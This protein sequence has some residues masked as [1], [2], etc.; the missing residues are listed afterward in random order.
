MKHLTHDEIFKSLYPVIN[1]GNIRRTAAAWAQ[2]SSQPEERSRYL[3]DRYRELGLDTEIITLFPSPDRVSETSCQAVK[4]LLP[5]KSA[6]IFFI[7]TCDS[8]AGDLQGAA[9]LEAAAALKRAV[10]SGILPPLEYSLCFF[11]TPRAGDFCSWAKE[12]PDAAGGVFL[13]PS[14][15]PL[16]EGEKESFRLLQELNVHPSLQHIMGR[17]VLKLLSQTGAFTYAASEGSA[18][19]ADL[20]QTF[21]WNTLQFS[22][23]SSLLS[24]SFL[25]TLAAFAALLGASAALEKYFLPAYLSQ[26]SCSEWQ[27]IFRERSLEALCLKEKDLESRMLRG[28]RLSQWSALALRSAKTAIQDPLLEKEFEELA[29][30]E[31]DAA[32]QLLC[33]GDVPRF[34]SD[35]NDLILEPLCRGP[36]Q[37]DTGSTFC[38]FDGRKTVFETARELWAC[39]PFGEHESWENFDEFLSLT[40][41][42]AENALKAGAARSVPR[43]CVTG[44]ELKDALRELGVRPGDILMVHSSY[45]S[46]G[47]FEGGPEGVVK[48]LQESVTSAG[49]LAMPA[50]SDCCDGGVSGVFD[51]EHTPVEKPVGIIPETFRQMEGVLRSPHPTHSLCAW[52]NNKTEF[53][54]QK[55]IYDCF[56][57]DGPWGRIACKGKILFIGETFDGNTFLH[58]CEAWYNNCLDATEAELKG[59][60]VRITNYPGGCRGSWYGKGRQAPWFQKIE[61]RGIFREGR[62]GKASLLLFEGAAFARAMQEIFKEDPALLLHRSGCRECARIRSKIQ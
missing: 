16:Q 49:L 57:A 12:H 60:K 56:A 42:L 10:E 23:K 40:A 62:A 17:K 19:G 58:A 55:D 38:R 48:A 30:K 27:E 54:S 29:R 37:Y 35:D 45:K 7:V 18:N 53:L 21:P 3:A 41:D 11:H 33:G 51:Q 1:G 26:I 36:F 28:I 22:A 8:P 59:K 34:R 46:F 43:S 13:V 39:A 20:M 31:T 25:K 15:V 47:T 6:K 44:E 9:A 50:L 2:D 24:F 14:P 52:G 4:A 5:G 61:A 32:L